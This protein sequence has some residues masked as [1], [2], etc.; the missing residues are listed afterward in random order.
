ML[1]DWRDACLIEAESSYDNSELERRETKQDV[2]R[3]MRVESQI[4]RIKMRSQRLDI[5]NRD[6]PVWPALYTPNPNPPPVVGATAGSK[7]MAPR[8]LLN[9]ITHV[10]S[11]LM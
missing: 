6:N 1:K 4:K 11:S 2:G 10:V 8:R 9:S 7:F 3:A 5:P